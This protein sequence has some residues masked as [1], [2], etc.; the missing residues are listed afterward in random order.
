MKATRRNVY[1]VSTL[2]AIISTIAPPLHPSA[3]AA[4]KLLPTGSGDDLHGPPSPDASR[5]F[6]LR[7]ADLGVP[8]LAFDDKRLILSPEYSKQTGFSIG[9]GYSTLL[10]DHTALGLLLT[11][12]GNKKEFLINTGLDLTDSQRLI[13]TYSYLRQDLDFDFRSGSEKAGISQNSGALSYQF[14]LGEGMLSAFELNGY[15]ADTG[16][17]DLAD[18]TYT[19]ETATL[20][21]KWNDPRRVAG[22]RVTGLQGRLVFTPLPGGTFK[23]GLGGEELAYDLLT[24]K[25]A[26]K[27]VT[28]SAEWTQQLADGY[29]VKASANSMAAMDRYS[30][31]LSRN[32]SGGHRIGVD[33]ASLQGRDGVPDDNQIRLSYSYSFSNSAPSAQA[34]KSRTAKT[35]SAWADGLLAQVAHRPSFLP[36][37]VVAKVDTSAAPIRLVVI[38]KTSIPAGAAINPAT[39]VISAPLGVAALG[40][41]GV[42]LNGGLFINTGQFGIADSSIV[43]DPGL[44]TEPAVGVTDTYE[45]T[46]NNVGGGTTLVTVRVSHGSVRIDS[47]TVSDVNEAFTANN[48][49]FGVD[50][51]N[52]AKTVSWS[53]RSGAG[54]SN[55]EG[56]GELSAS[57]TADGAR[58]TFTIAGLNVT[59]TPTEANYIGSDTGTIK[60]IDAVTPGHDQTKTITVE[61]INTDNTAPSIDNVNVGGRTIKK[62][63]AGEYV[64]ATVTDASGLSAAWD[65]AANYEV[66]VDDGFGA[67]FILDSSK[68]TVTRVADDRVRFTITDPTAIPNDYAGGQISVKAK[69]GVLTDGTGGNAVAGGT[70]IFLGNITN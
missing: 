69:A 54:A 3:V 8:L 29:T 59:Y 35:S 33:L 26:S 67:S 46:V 30:V 20:Y 24:G 22:G 58:G 63:T 27:R 11:F 56:T 39:G 19:V 52:A 28:G 57:I 6:S 65:V 55:P 17:T 62:L 45:V 68:Y 38:D 2:I 41:A 36:S 25:D 13:A 43:V 1:L 7:P 37:Q 44:I 4:E 53:D 10:S 50:I 9:A 48:F 21:E 64:E 40:I 14:S 61:N 47:I 5:S 32:L 70:Q 15:L 12:G 66:T 34:A 31:G 49:T 42:T 16:S 60:I 23:L 51:G 18:K